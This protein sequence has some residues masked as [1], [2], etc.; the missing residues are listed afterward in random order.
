MHRADR[1]GET[2]D[3]RHVQTGPRWERQG[4]AKEGSAFSVRDPGP[5][6]QLEGRL[7]AQQHPPQEVQGRIVTACVTVSAPSV[8]FL[9][10][11]GFIVASFR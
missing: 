4:E 9:F 8:M 1:E 10:S 2:G 7:S 6:V 3:R 11:N 5:P